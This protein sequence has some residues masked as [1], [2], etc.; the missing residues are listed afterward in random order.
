MAIYHATTK[1][2]ARSAGRSAIAVAAYRAGLKL[3]DERTGEVSDYSRK[4]GIES[5]AIFLPDGA[6]Q[7]AADRGRLWNAA[8][9]A[10]RRKDARIAREWEIALPAELTAEQR[11]ELAHGFARELVKRYGVAADVCI[12][13]PSRRGDDRNHHAHILLT[14]RQL[15]PD[16]FKDKASIELSDTKR[17]GMGL[18]SAADEV[19][20]VRKLWEQHANRALERAGV[21]ARIDSRSL[22]EQGADRQTTPRLGLAATSMTRRGAA[23]DREP[24]TEPRPGRRRRQRVEAAKRQRIEAELQRI[25]GELREQETRQAARTPADD[26]ADAETAADRRDGIT[27]PAPMRDWVKWRTQ[28][29]TDAGYEQKIAA[30]LAAFGRVSRTREGLR[31][32]L[33]HGGG[34]M[35]TGDRIRPASAQAND[36]EIY[37]ALRMAQAKGWGSPDKPL[38][39]TG[40]AEF[41]ERAAREAARIGLTVADADLQAVVQDAAA[42]QA[43]EQAAR[44]LSPQV[45]ENSRPAHDKPLKHQESAALP[46]YRAVDA[47]VQAWQQATTPQARRRAA[48]DWMQGMERVEKQ[49]GDVAAANDRTRKALGG[50]YADLMRQVQGLAR[51]RQRQ[52]GLER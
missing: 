14:T 2:V 16:G 38:T 20:D 6:P 31:F 8:E 39:I 25:E 1:P 34:V 30:E 46:D 13:A 24:A 5:R 41:R 27:A 7:W 43:E 49:G 33:K 15:G 40:S 10:E 21:A 50:G 12:H 11:R 52:R 47:A 26:R 18:P 22:D 3:T 29:L 48:Q 42:R 51:E 37:T 17:R 36:T 32:D 4:R 45:G 28:V 35:D 9:A 44:G 23:I 19:A